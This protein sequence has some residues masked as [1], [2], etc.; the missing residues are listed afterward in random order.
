MKISAEIAKL[1][2]L[3][4]QGVLTEDELNA[5]KESLLFPYID[6]ERKS[7]VNYVIFAL[8]LGIFGAHNFYVGRWKRGLC[9]LLLT[10][11]TCFIG[12]FFVKIWALVNIF[13]IKTDGNGKPFIPGK[14]LDYILG[15]LAYLIYFLL[16]VGG[17]LI[18]IG[19]VAVGYRVDRYIQSVQHT[20]AIHYISFPTKC[21]ELVPMD[22]NIG[23]ENCMVYPDGRIVLGHVAE[24]LQDRLLRDPKVKQIN[25]STIMIPADY[26]REQ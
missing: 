11:L 13:T 19:L 24:S 3:Y 26:G 5:S 17:T 16:L 1:D 14:K 4:E 8:F 20:A 7:R 2:A 21:A 9:Q 23:F 18:R 6:P 10:L 22:E 25:P 12:G 15:T